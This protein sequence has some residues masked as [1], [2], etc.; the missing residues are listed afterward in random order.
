VAIGGGES[1]QFH[2]ESE[3][4]RR[5]I[6]L[7]ARVESFSS[8]CY[9]DGMFILLPA[10]IFCGRLLGTMSGRRAVVISGTSSSDRRKP[11]LELFSPADA[12]ESPI[13]REMAS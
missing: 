11:T 13:E 7:L 9:F 10:L 6:H 1:E 2:Y 5:S 4:V 8:R 12:S 3:L